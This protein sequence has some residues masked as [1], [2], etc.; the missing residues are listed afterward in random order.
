MEY[1]LRSEERDLSGFAGQ[2]NNQI[3]GIVI[4]SP[5]GNKKPKLNQGETQI[6]KRY[7]KPNP[8]YP[9]LFDAIEYGRVAPIYISSALGSNYRYAGVDVKTNEVVSFGSRS[10]RVFETF[11]SDSYV[12][13]EKNAN[14]IAASASDGVVKTVSGIID[15]PLPAIADTLQLKVGARILDV[16]LDTGLNTLTGDSLSSGSFNKDSGAYNLEFV[17][18]S[19]SVATYLSEVPITSTLDLSVNASDKLINLEIDGVLYQNINLGSASATTKANI[20]SAINSAVGKTVAS[21]SGDYVK[22]DGLIASANVGSIKIT[23]PSSGT[24]ALALVFNPDVTQISVKNSVSPTGFVPRAGEKVEFNYNYLIDIKSDVAFSLFTESPFDD[25]LETYQ[26]KISR[27]GTTGR[28][29][30]AVL[31][32]VGSNGNSEI[33]TYNFSLDKEKNGF[34]ASIYYEDVFLDDDYLKIFVNTSYSGIADPLI[35]TVTLL[36]GDRGD[37]PTD[38]DFLECWQFFQQKNLYKC[39]N[40]LDPYSINLANMI[41]VIDQFQSQAHGIEVIPF[42]NKVQA[43]I[44]YRKNTGVDYDKVS[45]YTNWIKIKDPYNNSFAWISGVGKIGVKYSQMNDIFDG[46]A[47]AG[48]DENSR[49]GQLKGGFEIVAVE[50]DYSS[51]DEQALDEAQINPL[52][53]YDFDGVVIMGQKTMQ[54]PLSDT[55]YTA[56]RRLFNKVIDD[57]SSKILRKQIFKLNDP[58]HRLLAKTQTD[59]YLAP[60]IAANLFRDIYVQCDDK[61]NDDDVLQIKNFI[62]DIYVKVTPFSE[63][64]LLR[65]TRLSQGAVISQ[66]IEQ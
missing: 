20:V 45:L 56:H 30:S 14:Y 22:I 40:F 7:G 4:I 50:N 59:T 60:I 62:L 5:K 51:D 65:L 26:I 24:S 63:Y 17:G 27:T 52:I 64:V 11:S 6:L 57:V 42:G 3:G 43:A 16:T 9:G 2:S 61:N 44:A 12:S 8:T 10:G 15:T 35:S 28:R 1:R 58:F 18:D 66:F 54:V 32:Q 34:G 37:D 53:K 39:K 47:P 49:G 55:S 36:G 48:L 29:Y 23:N 38:S 13:V 31:Y 25:D 19:G 46:L 33:K 21:E 41:N